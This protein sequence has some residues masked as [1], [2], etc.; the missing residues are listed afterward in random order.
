MAIGIR[1]MR[2]ERRKCIAGLLVWC[3]ADRLQKFNA[4]NHC[5]IN[6]R[7]LLL[8]TMGKAGLAAGRGGG[9]WSEQ[10]SGAPRLSDTVMR[11]AYAPA[12]EP[13]NSSLTPTGGHDGLQFG[14]SRDSWDRAPPIT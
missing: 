6:Q 5:V 11:N 7:W 14:D 2:V 3:P 4:V 12:R 13:R 1:A 10:A 9:V 8:A